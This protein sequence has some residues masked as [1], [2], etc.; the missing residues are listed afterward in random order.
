MRPS[1]MMGLCSA[2]MRCH[3]ALIFWRTMNH[4][5]P[6]GVCACARLPGHT[7]S[8]LTGGGLAWQ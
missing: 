4:L 3:K 5:C 7:G 8:A 6:E 1:L 2:A